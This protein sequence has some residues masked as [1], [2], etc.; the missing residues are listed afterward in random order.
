MKIMPEKKN[1]KPYKGNQINQTT[2][3]NF[4]DDFNTWRTTCQNAG[5]GALKVKH[6]TSLYEMLKNHMTED[7]IRDGSRNKGKGGEGAQ[8]YIE[9]IEGMID[10]VDMFTDAHADMLVLYSKS[11]EEIKGKGKS[12][13]APDAF[14][15]AFIVFTEQEY[16]H[17]NQKLAPRTVQGHYATKWYT[18]KNGGDPVDG[19][20]MTGN[21]PPH[22]ALFSKTQTDFANPK[23]LLWIMKEAAGDIDDSELDVIIDVIGGG[24]A[25][26]DIDA[27]TPIEKF[28]DKIAKEATYWK[29]G[30]LLISKVS[31]EFKA[32][33]FTLTN[34]D[35][36]AIK[37][38]AILNEKDSPTG[39]IRTVRIR[40]TTATPIVT[41]VDRALKRK[42]TT[43]SPE[44]NQ[45]T[46]K[47]YRAWQ[48]K[49]KRGFDYRY[50]AREAYGVT[51][52]NMKD[53]DKD[54]RRSKYKPDTK[55][56][57]M[58]QQLLWR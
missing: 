47:G 30:R 33:E 51:E 11:L 1:F 49:T 21:N 12:L 10:G 35:Q 34:N 28:F 19:D 17:D 48:N 16:G 15:P 2:K 18:D 41:L 14:D 53:K 50:T 24:T 31:K 52:A 26:E 22:Q 43:H 46:G 57:K 13:D 4:V 58:W 27:I 38:I 32:T 8:N 5:A 56:I 45:D 9:T 36:A 40:A 25:P 42:N 37:E 7:L 55:I 39:Y 29:G 6:I 3:G 54:G 44:I 23:G 20:W